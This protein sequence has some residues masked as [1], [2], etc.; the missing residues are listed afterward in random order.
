[1]GTC[2]VHQGKYVDEG[3]ISNVE[4]SLVD[5]IIMQATNKA[6]LVTGSTFSARIYENRLDRNFDPKDTHLIDMHGE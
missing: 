5:L 3:S 6:L 1:M 2:I 4:A